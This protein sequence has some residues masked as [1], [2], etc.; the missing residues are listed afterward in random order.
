MRCEQIRELLSPYMDQMT[1]DRENQM[2]EAHLTDCTACR[3]ELEQLQLIQSLLHRLD[4]PQLPEGFAADFH[5]RLRKEYRHR[6][7]APAEIKRPRKQGG[8]AAAVAGLALAVGIY[9][10]TFLP[11][12]SIASL[13]Q[14]RPDPEKKAPTIAVDDIIKRMQQ[15]KATDDQQP[16]VADNPASQNPDADPPVVQNSPQPAVNHPETES[17]TGR[18]PA[19]PAAVAA[20][21]ADVVR[22]QVKVDNLTRSVNEVIQ[23]ADAAEAESWATPGT[24]FQAMVGTTREITIKAPPA[25]AEKILAQLKQVGKVGAPLTEQVELTGQY[26]EALTSIQVIDEE[27]KALE[28][29][30]GESDQ[31]RVD[32]LQQQL[33]KWSDRKAQIERDAD[34]VT[35]KVYLSEEEVNP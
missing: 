23:I 32:S 15:W 25:V 12:G 10:S 26:A 3:Q 1:D 24:A 9:A 13:W 6:L 22:S 4:A 19:E 21:I 7:L 14:D 33:K 2:V 27:I 11:V 5:Q 29:Q 17:D 16:V 31:A 8:I 34:M 18:Q 20:K 28:A 30:G 35:I